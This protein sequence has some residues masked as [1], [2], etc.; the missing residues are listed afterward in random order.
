MEFLFLHAGG[1]SGVIET[2]GSAFLIIAAR[3]IIAS[4]C[5]LEDMVTSN[6]RVEPGSFL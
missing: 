3:L 5:A 6:G 4:R 2:F 1:R